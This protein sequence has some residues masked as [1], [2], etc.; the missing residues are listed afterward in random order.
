MKKLLLIVCISFFAQAQPTKFIKLPTNAPIGRT[1]LHD[2]TTKANAD[3]LLSHNAHPNAQLITGT[4]PI[5]LAVARNKKGVVNSLLRYGANINHSDNA[6]NTTLSLAIKTGNYSMVQ[7]LMTLGAKFP[8]GKQKAIEYAQKIYDQ[9]TGKL[10]QKME[11]TINSLR[12]YY[13]A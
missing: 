9:A 4:T 8:G 11:R 10:K 5:H 2:A 7:R 3:H 13:P 12:N 6:G 1:A